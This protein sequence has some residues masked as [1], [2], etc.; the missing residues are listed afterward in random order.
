MKGGPSHSPR[1]GRDAVN[2]IA[3]LTQDVQADLSVPNDLECIGVIGVDGVGGSSAR[4]AADV[5]P[6]FAPVLFTGF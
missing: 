2:V 4:D 6:A 1:L 5:T 3:G